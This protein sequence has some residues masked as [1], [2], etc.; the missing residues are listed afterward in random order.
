MY[1]RCPFCD[2]TIT[3]NKHPCEYCGAASSYFVLVPNA[4]ISDDAYQEPPVRI[5]QSMDSV[6]LA[7]GLCLFVLAIIGVLIQPVGIVTG[8]IVHVVASKILKAK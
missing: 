8:V 5:Y 7:R 3:D 1:Y 2:S 6:T 4:A